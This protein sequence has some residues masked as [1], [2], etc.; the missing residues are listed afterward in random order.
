MVVCPPAKG[1][2]VGWLASWS[3]SIV[4]PE[5]VRGGGFADVMQEGVLPVLEPRGSFVCDV[6]DVAIECS[7]M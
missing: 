1:K 4:D 6:V 5:R 7:R 3:L 2:V